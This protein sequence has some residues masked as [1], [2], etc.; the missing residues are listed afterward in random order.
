MGDGETALRLLVAGE[1]PEMATLLHQLPAVRLVG[2]VTD[3]RALAALAACCGADVVLASR[4]VFGDVPLERASEQLDLLA[5]GARTALVCRERDA[6]AA[7]LPP[8]RPAFVLPDDLQAAIRFAAGRDGVGD[9]AAQGLRPTPDAGHRP[10]PGTWR[11]LESPSG[12]GR[13]GPWGG[14][15][16]TPPIPLCQVISV[17]GPKGGVGKTTVAVNLALCL[18]QEGEPTALVD[19]DLHGSSV[20]VH[21]DL[22]DDP[23]LA[24]LVSALPDIASD[25]VSAYWH[26]HVPTGLHAVTAPHRPELADLV[27]PDAVQ[28]ALELLAARHRFL[29][30]DHATNPASQMLYDTLDRSHAILL[31]TSLDAA[32]LRSVRLLLEALRRLRPGLHGRVQVVVNGVPPRPAIGLRDAEEFVGARV[33]AALPYDRGAEQAVADGAPLQLGGG[34]YAR[35]VRALTRDAGL[36]PAAGTAERRAGPLAWLRRRS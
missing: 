26:E 21:L 6:S 12:A 30:V 2:H 13:P 28:R 35:A 15:R 24:D 14:G 4:E 22:L 18:A 10:M 34:E 9:A 7:A 8:G 19:L 5:P 29:V 3:L 16:P 31:V 1:V 36:L 27:R 17:Y 23:T 25:G 32:S 20:A 11:A 33:V